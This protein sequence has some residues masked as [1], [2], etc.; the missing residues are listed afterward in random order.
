MRC[1]VRRLAG[2]WRRKRRRSVRP[3]R[4]RAWHGPET[5]ETRW[6]LAAES[7]GSLRPEPPALLALP[8]PQQPLPAALPLA[9]A[10]PHS[11]GPP[12]ARLI[13]HVLT[14][15]GDSQTALQRK[16]SG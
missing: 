7:A 8:L 9:A 6:L 1:W 5:L 10:G 15:P 2:N 12:P 11:L 14:V 4:A 16:Q 13:D 3:A